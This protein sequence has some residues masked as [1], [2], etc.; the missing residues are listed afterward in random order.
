VLPKNVC[1]IETVNPFA[2]C[3]TLEELIVLSPYF[4]PTSGLRHPKNLRRSNM[5]MIERCASV[6]NRVL[7]SFP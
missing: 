2:S 4:V 6:K 5:G 3:F 7:V 1:H